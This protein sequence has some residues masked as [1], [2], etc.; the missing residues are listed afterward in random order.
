MKKITLLMLA[1]SVSAPI[2]PLSISVKNTTDNELNYIVA[3]FKFTG[4]SD[5]DKKAIKGKVTIKNLKSG[6]TA[7]F[8]SDKAL[9]RSSIAIDHFDKKPKVELVYLEA[10]RWKINWPVIG[11]A[12]ETFKQGTKYTH[13]VV[14]AKKGRLGITDYDIEPVKSFLGR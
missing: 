4:P 1:M 9:Y 13:F 12:E 8:N 14:T 11:G 3:T 7:T 10:K 6:A 5:V 2:F